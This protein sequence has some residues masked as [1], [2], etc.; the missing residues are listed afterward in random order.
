MNIKGGTHLDLNDRIKIQAGLEKGKKLKYIACDISCDERT[1]SKEIRKR[2]IMTSNRKVIITKGTKDMCK[3]VLRF[4]YVCN[5]CDKRRKCSN[6]H[7]FDYDAKSAQENYERILKESRQGLDLTLEEKETIDIILKQGS[8]KGQSIAHIY[9]GNKE[10][11]PCSETTLYRIINDSKTITQRIDLRRAVKLKPRKKYTYDKKEDIRIYEG[12]TYTDFIAYISKRV[13]TNLV[14]IDI[15]EGIVSDKKCL[16]TIHFT[17]LHFM[18]IRLL[19]KKTRAN[20]SKQ[21]INFFKLFGEDTYRQLFELILTDRGIEFMNP[22]IIEMRKDDIS[23]TRL[24]FCDSYS[25]YQ[26]G[27]IEEN[28][29]LIRYILPKGTSFENLTQSKVDL[30]ASHINSYYRKSIDNTPYDLFV[31]FFSKEIA[32]KLNIVKIEAKEVTLKSTLIK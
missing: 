4:P 6:F 11:I 19:N 10:R 26:K 2:R 17:Q 24:F 5:G 12:R 18:I 29:T 9:Q 23:L 27:A 16:L 3:K 28:H 31:T 32:D 8:D 21:F 14:E 30:M 22:E 1:I 15:V 25:S 20:V 13:I 7:F